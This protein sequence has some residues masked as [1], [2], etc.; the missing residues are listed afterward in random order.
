M[1]YTIVT[2][3]Y[4]YIYRKAC[5]IQLTDTV[6]LTGGESSFSR[7]QEYNLQGSV[8]R[9][10]DLNTGRYSHACGHYTHNGQMVSTQFSTHKSINQIIFKPKYYNILSAGVDCQWWIHWIYPSLLHRDLDPRLHCMDPGC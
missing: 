10:P 5:A 8:A 9:L 7:V 4:P 6:I 1:K 2:G 3:I